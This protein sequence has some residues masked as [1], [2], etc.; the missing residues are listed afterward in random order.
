MSFT[1]SVERFLFVGLL[2]WISLGLAVWIAR[3]KGPKWVSSVASFAV[4][5]LLIFP[6]WSK[7]SSDVKP[8]DVQDFY[9]PGSC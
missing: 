9:V 8:K 1:L 7:N 3:S 2:F 5:L 4:L 6:V